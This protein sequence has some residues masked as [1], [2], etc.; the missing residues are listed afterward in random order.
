[1]LRTGVTTD[2][3]YGYIAISI[4][5]TSFS[6]QW[7]CHIDDDVYVNVPQLSHQLQQ[8]D[9]H[10]PYYIGKWPGMAR[11]NQS[12]VNVSNHAIYMHLLFTCWLY[13]FNLANLNENTSD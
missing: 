12:F 5:S 8:F 9:P 10:K 7:F 1:M 2:P 6:Y 13:V 4:S 3:I 11:K